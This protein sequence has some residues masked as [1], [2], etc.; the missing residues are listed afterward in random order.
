MM[1]INSEWILIAVEV[2]TKWM[3]PTFGL[4][5]GLMKINV[6]DWFESKNIQTYRGGSLEY[7]LFIGRIKGL[8]LSQI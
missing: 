4:A 5:L 2:P 6:L 8:P 3:S 1:F 7:Q